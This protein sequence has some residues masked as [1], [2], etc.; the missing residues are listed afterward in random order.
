MHIFG[1]YRCLSVHG[2]W[3]VRLCRPVHTVCFAGLLRLW[4][5]S[6]TTDVC[7]STRPTCSPCWSA[8]PSCIYRSSKRPAATSSR[9]GQYPLSQVCLSVTRLNPLSQVCL[10]VTRLYPLS[11]VCLSVTRLYQLS[12]V[13]SQ[14]HAFV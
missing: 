6:P 2:F 9:T 10:S 5:T 14:C 1:W 3:L 7:S 13:F 11:Q 4:S 8:P 12:Q